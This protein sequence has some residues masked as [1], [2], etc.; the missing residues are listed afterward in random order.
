MEKSPAL[1]GDAAEEVGVLIVNLPDDYTFTPVIAFI[2]YHSAFKTVGILGGCAV[3][4]ATL[5]GWIEPRPFHAEWR[6]DPFFRP[7]Y[8]TI[9]RLRFQG[10]H[11]TRYIPSNYIRL[12]RPVE[13]PAVSLQGRE[14]T[15]WP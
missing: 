9:V 12:S 8:L 6:E 13:I 2:V 1:A 5:V 11:L 14:I 3:L 10:E 4:T 15:C 7:I